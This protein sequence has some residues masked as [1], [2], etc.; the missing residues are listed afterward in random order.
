MPAPVVVGVAMG[1][2]TVLAAGVVVV[3]GICLEIVALA[4]AGVVNAGVVVH[5]A[6]EMTFV[7]VSPLTVLCV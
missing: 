3:V 4:T 7:A 1:G 6:A 2:V 5:V